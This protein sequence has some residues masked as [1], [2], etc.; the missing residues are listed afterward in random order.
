MA[1]LVVNLCEEFK[2]AITI[3]RK[4]W[5][6][7][8]MSDALRKGIT[9]STLYKMVQE[10]VIHSFARGLYQLSDSK[11]FQTPDLV[12]VACKIPK[13]VLYLFSQQCL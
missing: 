1:S 6:I 2:P 11:P 13:A 9:K 7:M 12:A 5:G 8:R 10:K 3:F 4:H